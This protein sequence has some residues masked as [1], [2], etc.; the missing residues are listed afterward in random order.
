MDLSFKSMGVVQGLIMNYRID[1]NSSFKIEIT[2][3]NQE[4]NFPVITTISS[5]KHFS[6]AVTDAWNP[7]S[8]NLPMV[9]STSDREDCTN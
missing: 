1:K 4:P 2:L 6:R 7:I 8:S 5:K 9:L 3:S